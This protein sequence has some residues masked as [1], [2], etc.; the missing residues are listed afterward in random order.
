ME[1]PIDVL[2]PVRDAAA[3]LPA[4]LN[5][6]AAQTQRAFRLIAVDDGS[7]D[8]SREI[9]DA[10]ARTDSRVVVINADGRGIV[11]AL[12]TGLR[13]ATAP[14]VARM[15]ADDV[16]H[17]ERLAKQ[18]ALLH[19]RPD[20]GAVGCLVNE[21]GLAGGFAHYLAWSNALV[22]PDAIAQA[23]FIES[24][25]V[26]PTLCF[27]RAVVEQ[28]G[29]YRDGDFPEDYELWLRWMDAG[30]RF[31]KIAEPLL[32]WTDH[33]ARLTR[34]D[35]RY[36][37]EA[38]Y[39]IKLMYLARWLLRHNPHRERVWIWG[40]GPLTRKRL[41][42][43]I[44]HGIRIEGWIDIDPDKIGRMTPDGPVFGPTDLPPPDACF[45][46]TAVGSRGAREQITAHLHSRGFEE[47]RH[48]LC[49]A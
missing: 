33:P 23:R 46:L 5:S 25:L 37:V 6:I 31:A 38:F 47:S 35:P 1:I 9:L 27:R 10:A 12:N 20:L 21:A 28:H 22:T 3:T 15:D 32:H 2:L 34:T 8:A 36:S 17:P 44:E 13:H 29:G 48:F 45:V 43:L 7:V 30:V 40:A 11:A 18:A 14:L 41:R 16:M 4:C 42:T 49:V 39:R 26:H 24:P 19:D